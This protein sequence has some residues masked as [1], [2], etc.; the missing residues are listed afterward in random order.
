[1]IQAPELASKTAEAVEVAAM[2]D[3]VAV[4]PA[5][6]E[7]RAG[8]IGAVTWIASPR[9]PTAVF[10]RVFGLAGAG[11]AARDTLRACL[12]HYRAAGVASV[13]VHATEDERDVLALLH[14]EGFRIARRR[15]WAKM[16][17]G[18]SPPPE[19]PTPYRIDEIGPERARPAAEIIRGAFGLPDESAEWFEGL[20]GRPR[21]RAYGVLDGDRM[22]GTGF[23]FIDGPVAWLGF[24]ATDPA[25]RG[26]GAQGAVMARRIRDAIAAG[27]QTIAVETGEPVG[28]EPNPSLSNMRRCGFERASSRLN[29]ERAL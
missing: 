24:G 13:W 29:F 5:S 9:L 4:A 19:I 20:V 12:E 18:T 2:C 21:W 10:N 17:R 25:H 16:V 11:D 23:T 14:D 27:C 7:L 22:V 15:S 3:L 26:R 28:D 1:M 6:L 8:R